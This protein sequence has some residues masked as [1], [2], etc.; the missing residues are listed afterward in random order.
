MSLVDGEVGKDLAYRN[1]HG[2]SITKLDREVRVWIG[3]L[4]IY[5]DIWSE[6]RNLDGIPKST[7]VDFYRHLLSRESDTCHW[8]RSHD[9]TRA[10]VADQS[11]SSLWIRGIPG[12][13]K[14]VLAAFLAQSLFETTTARPPI[15]F[16]CDAKDE[17]KMTA[18]SVFRNLLIQIVE[19]ESAVQDLMSEEYKKSGQVRITSPDKLRKLFLAAVQRL[20]EITIIIDGLDELDQRGQDALIEALRSL[21]TCRS[22]LVKICVTSRDQHMR[23]KLSFVGRVINI[24][25]SLVSR[26]IETFIDGAVDSNEA[27]Q[28]LM[29]GNE[30]SLR[31]LKQELLRCADGQFLLPKYMIEEAEY[32]GMVVLDQIPSSLAAYYLQFLCRIEV[33]RRSFASRAFRWMAYARRPLTIAELA[34]ALDMQSKEFCQGQ[35]RKVC[36]SLIAIEGGGVRLVHTSVQQFLR[37]GVDFFLSKELS[38]FACDMDDAHAQLATRCVSYLSLRVFAR[39]LSGLSRFTS[40]DTRELKKRHSFL[41]Y[42]ALFWIDHVTSASAKNPQ[43]LRAVD[44]YTRISNSRTWLE[45]MFLFSYL[46]KSSPELLAHLLVGWLEREDGE[47]LAGE[48]I[49]VQDWAHQVL[50]LRLRFHYQTLVQSASEV[51]FVREVLPLVPIFDSRTCQ[52]VTVSLEERPTGTN[53]GPSGSEN[54]DAETGRIQLT[55]VLSDRFLIKESLIVEWDSTR[56]TIFSTRFASPDSQWSLTAQDLLTHRQDERIIEIVPRREV[57]TAAV[58]VSAKGNFI[59]VV[60]AESDK[61]D[62]EDLLQIRLYVWRIAYGERD[63]PIFQPLMW[64]ES[65][66]GVGSGT[67]IGFVGSK[68]TIAISDDETLL[69]TPLGGFSIADGAKIWSS[70]SFFRPD[71]RDLTVNLHASL[72]WGTSLGNVMI[73]D[74]RTGEESQVQSSANWQ[75]VEILGVSPG[76]KIAVILV[77]EQKPDELDSTFMLGLVRTDGTFMCVYRLTKIEAQKTEA[78]RLF[79]QAFAN[80]GLTSVQDDGRFIIGWPTGPFGLFSGR[81]YE[82]QSASWSKQRCLETDA[83]QKVLSLALAAKGLYVLLDDATIRH[84][85]LDGSSEGPI[86][87]LPISIKST[88]RNS[89]I[90]SDLSP[91]QDELIVFHPSR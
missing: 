39:P 30:Q 73:F 90:I 77:W 63:M 15:L 9:T 71:V 80:G 5:E 42:S 55:S 88:T 24:D 87:T 10:W 84:V 50:S 16:F 34:V 36:G 11:S 81:F 45:A 43:L 61:S 70:S 27:I 54:V 85:E 76:G 32:R 12:C 14:S 64:T 47:F 3:P 35:L 6:Y 22:C 18:S 29:E 20:K 17:E 75:K 57:V 48:R 44:K 62:S 4:E 13:G 25:P 8:L 37:N 7:D 89:E 38:D 79:S 2:P 91:S 72:F 66:G 59:A 49:N 51:H 53:G 83:G 56:K 41:L 33:A 60:I 69:I 1:P 68:N 52:E 67:V 31:K 86:T 46:P 19:T 28:Q 21:R 58:T 40:P 82:D 65:D 26:D 78:E 74:A 23:D